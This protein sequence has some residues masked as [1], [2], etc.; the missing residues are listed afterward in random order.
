MCCLQ[1]TDAC[2]R[3]NRRA[4]PLVGSLRR[5]GCTIFRTVIRGSTRKGA[6]CPPPPPLSLSERSNPPSP[7][8]DLPCQHH[9]ELARSLY[10]SLSSICNWFG[11]DD[12]RVVW[13]FPVSAGG[14]TDLRK[15]SLENRQVAIKSYRRYLT[16]DSSQI[17]VRFAQEALVCSRLSHRHIVSFVGIYSTT[18]HPLSLVFKFAGHL[19]LRRYL[20]SHPTAKRLELLTGIARGLD[21]MHD[22]N[23]AHGRLE[24]EN[25]LVDFDGTAQIAGLGSALILGHTASQSE[26]SAGRL[27]RGIAPELMR[28]EEYGFPYPQNSKAS[29]I[30][31]FGVFTG[32]VA[33]SGR[34][35]VL[36]LHIMR[37][38]YQPT[39]PDHPELTDQV[40]T[41]MEQCWEGEPSK[42]T[43]IKQVIRV[44]EA[45][46]IST[47]GAHN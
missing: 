29:D 20:K 46:H 14:F 37:N 41:A 43:T 9:S 24:T 33:F 32:H 44:L 25:I 8:D 30:Y 21:H 47:V 11:E 3:A 45:G 15:G 18:T 17:S 16:A 7:N 34:L 27:F 12:I 26:M 40:W 28:P 6:A 36:A 38:D 35:E 31:A 13:E 2:S 19:D 22:L 39:R 5:L 1:V 42:R 10:P 4:V 23:I